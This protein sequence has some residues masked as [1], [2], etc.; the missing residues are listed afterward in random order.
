MQKSNNKKNIKNDA[1]KNETL[2]GQQT[3]KNHR[4]GLKPYKYDF[5]K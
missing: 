4:Y 1:L 2:H 5:N 3:S